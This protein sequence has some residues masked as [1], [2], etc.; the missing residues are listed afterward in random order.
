MIGGMHSHCMYPVFDQ[1]TGELRFCRRRP[2]NDQLGLDLCH[3]HAYHL[4]DMVRYKD[5]TYRKKRDDEIEAE[6]RNRNTLN[7]E[8]IARA[9]E[10]RQI[11]YVRRNDGAIKIG[12]SRDVRGRIASLRTVSPVELLASHLGDFETEREMHLRFEVHRLDGEWFAPCEELLSHI[13]EVNASS[14]EVAA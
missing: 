5:E 14:P 2:E 4:V 13:A 11:Y 12:T 3:Q 10:A 9:E 1:W 7:E 6:R 8:R